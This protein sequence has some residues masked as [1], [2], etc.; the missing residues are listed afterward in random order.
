MH[1]EKDLIDGLNKISKELAKKQRQLIQLPHQL[2]TAHRRM[3]ILQIKQLK[4]QIR[5][6]ENMLVIE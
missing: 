1:T 4:E 3:L 5:A 6:A 2:Q